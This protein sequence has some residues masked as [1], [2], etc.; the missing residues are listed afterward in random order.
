MEIKWKSKGKYEDIL[1]DFYNGI[2]KITINRPEV[3]NA[4]R[5]ETISELSEA[6]K[7]AAEDD[8]TGAVSYTHLTLPTTVIV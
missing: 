8:E 3:R 1:V 5:P 7:L 4:F 2:T 6:F